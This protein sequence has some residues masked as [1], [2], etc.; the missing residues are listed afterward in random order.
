MPSR[1]SRA[2]PASAAAPV[3]GAKKGARLPDCP[4][5]PE[6]VRR[7]KSTMTPPLREPPN[8]RSKKQISSNNN[9]PGNESPSLC[10]S[11]PYFASHNNPDTSFPASSGGRARLL[12]AATPKN[13]SDKYL[14]PQECTEKK[15]EDS[16]K[17]AEP[18]Y[19]IERVRGGK[20]WVSSK[21][22][23]PPPPINSSLMVGESHNLLS[24]WQG[25]IHRQA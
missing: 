16:Q 18:I 25:Y 1:S 4:N 10:R 21:L 23:Q 19:L 20:N 11:V 6:R 14:I 9:F 3:S 7:N 22:T 12:S 8:Y 5:S 17:E 24:P 13:T 2:V 15:L